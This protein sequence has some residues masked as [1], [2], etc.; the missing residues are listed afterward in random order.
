MQP[1]TARVGLETQSDQVGSSG[2]ASRG[3]VPGPC[4]A[5]TSATH[6]A[7]GVS[8]PHL[9]GHGLDWQ[10]PPR[11]GEAE[12]QW[13]TSFSPTEECAGA[14]KWEQL[15]EKRRLGISADGTGELGSSVLM[16]RVGLVGLGLPPKGFGVHWGE[17][18]QW[19]ACHCHRLP[20]S[21]QH[22]PPG[23]PAPLPQAAG[24]VGVPAQAPGPR[25]RGTRS[26]C[27]HALGSAVTKCILGGQ[28]GPSAWPTPE[29]EF[30]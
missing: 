3:H 18:S 6:V 4:P 23:F 25:P 27:P 21:P 24:R 14:L 16:G 9:A 5:P 7:C 19:E 17:C 15:Q 22:Q 20:A 13:D 2:R 8:T 26:K 1:G 10:C 12:G 11:H 29:S 28:D 30:A